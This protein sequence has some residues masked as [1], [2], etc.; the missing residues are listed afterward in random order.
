[1]ETYRQKGTKDGQ[2]GKQFEAE[3][4]STVP[5]RQLRSGNTG[6]SSGSLR[7]ESGTPERPRSSRSPRSSTGLRGASGC[8]SRCSD[9]P[10]PAGRGSCSPSSCCW[11][12]RR[13]PSRS[14]SSLPGSPRW[15]DTP[16]WPCPAAAPHWRGAA[17]SGWGGYHLGDTSQQRGQE[18]RS[19]SECESVSPLEDFL[20]AA[21]SAPPHKVSLPFKKQLKHLNTECHQTERPA[22]NPTAL[23]SKY[24]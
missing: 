4:S 9:R 11:R 15:P 2:T 5:V 14:D 12:R 17:P 18:A 21:V 7:L 1:M 10:S 20:S 13:P 8:C 24:R 19:E 6:L 16:A 23:G 22:T 3:T